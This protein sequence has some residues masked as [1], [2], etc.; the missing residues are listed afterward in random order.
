MSAQKQYTLWQLIKRLG[1][2]LRPYVI[3][4]MAA[5]ILLTIASL[6]S[7]LPP[8][9]LK[10]LI[11]DGIQAGNVSVL[12]AMAIV[13]I[14]LTV[15]SGVTRWLMEYVHEWVSARFIADLRGHL[16]QHILHQPMR[17]FSSIKTGDVLGTLRNDI[18][19]VYGVIVNTFLG[20]LSEVV[21]IAGI[22]ILLF[23]LNPVLAL[24]AISFIPPLYLALIYSGRRMRKLSLT[25]R[26]KDVNLLDFF[27]EKL[28]NI[29]LLKLYHREAYEEDHLK[30]LSK[31]LISATLNSVRYR[32]ISIFIIGLL[33]SAASVIIIWHGGHRV[34]QGTLT[35][36]S[37]F[38][39]YLYTTRLYGPIQS[40][41]NRGVD[42]YN[43]LASAER[44]VNYMDLESEI[45][46]AENPKRPAK[47]QGDIAFN[48]VSFC[49]PGS[50]SPV[51]QDFT[52]SIRSGQ[53]IALVGP[54]GTGKT[55]L[56][57][58]LGRLYD[59][60]SGSIEI[61]GYDIR[62]LALETLY[63]SIGVI[64]Q[65]S[66][67]FNT[68]IEENIRYGKVDASID[69]I[70]DAAK[71]AH[72]HDFIQQLPEGYQTK[73]GP[74][75]VKLSGG[76]RQRLAIA[77][78]ILK[79]A[80]IWILDEFTSSL[81]SRSELAVYENIMPL[82][83]EKTALIIAHRLSTI[84]SADLVVVIQNG[85][86]VE[87]GTHLELYC[88]KGLYKKLFDNQL[89]DNGNLPVEESTDGLGR[90]SL[91]VSESILVSSE[92]RKN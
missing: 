36:G 83:S 74:R 78:V 43:G 63:D 61:D 84:L 4:Y 69:E 5:I 31:E 75:G 41:A 56:V 15:L 14:G 58:L 67:L 73:I 22:S 88:R 38:A 65:D 33:T 8:Y 16:F 13:L 49:Y 23:Y 70:I 29:Q 12:N 1:P 45:V 55:T 32:F 79:D 87:V 80:P 57:N 91:A 2:F 42:I 51:V 27:H 7:L 6:L 60:D 64:P 20:S 46:E 47:I 25:V 68:S 39:F 90:A 26:S 21:Q 19:A 3:K 81:D 52:L 86:I 54:S 35:F 85:G 44:L 24:I 17:F 18:T 53:K 62:E 72:L 77:R 30:S 76:Q 66:Y 89:W 92:T 50:K 10:L 59:I 28:G 82:L 37:L 48:N 71:K 9:I 11:D 34:L 40:L